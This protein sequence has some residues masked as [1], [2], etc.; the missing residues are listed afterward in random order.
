MKNLSRKDDLGFTGQGMGETPRT[1]NRV[2]YKE[3]QDFPKSSF[4]VPLADFRQVERE[5]NQ[6]IRERDQARSNVKPMGAVT[7]ARNGYIQEIEA[8]RDKAIKERDAWFGLAQKLRDLLAP[9]AWLHSNDYPNEAE[10][11]VAEFDERA[12]ACITH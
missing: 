12:Q 1:D 5:L 4:V 8:Q 2:E 7:I 9:I 6:A 3:A 11:A 10:N